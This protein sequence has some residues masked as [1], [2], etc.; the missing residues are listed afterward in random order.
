MPFDR[1][2]PFRILASSV[3]CGGYAR[4]NKR[5]HSRKDV[6]II[7]LILIVV[8]WL[9]TSPREDDLSEGEEPHGHVTSIS[10]VRGSRRLGIAKKLMLQSRELFLCYYD[11]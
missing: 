5:L 1:S 11:N 8:S 2:I 6:S 3:I 9:I 7:C 10:V 4:R